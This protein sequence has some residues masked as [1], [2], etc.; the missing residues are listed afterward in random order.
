MPVRTNHNNE[1]IIESKPTRNGRVRHLFQTSTCTLR[2]V[3]NSEAR[4]DN[5]RFEHV[6]CLRSN[7]ERDTVTRGKAKRNARYRLCVYSYY[8][9]VADIVRRV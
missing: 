1:L 5:R 7:D 4:L 9:A 6:P 3:R 2:T 8:K